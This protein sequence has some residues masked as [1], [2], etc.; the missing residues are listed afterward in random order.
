MLWLPTAKVVMVIAAWPAPFSVTGAPSDVPASENE[1]VP[2]GTVVPVVGV[3]V[4]VNVT[5]WPKFEE[6]EGFEITAV[7]VATFAAAFTT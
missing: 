5:D 2:V 7:V 3:T 1:T 4:A 6:L